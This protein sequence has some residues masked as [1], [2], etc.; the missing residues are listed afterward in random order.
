VGILLTSLNLSFL[1]LSK[2]FENKLS[3]SEI[4]QAFQMK[5]RDFPIENIEVL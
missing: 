1:Y 4:K 2:S 5:N 3:F